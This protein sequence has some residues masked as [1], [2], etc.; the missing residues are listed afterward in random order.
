[1][2]PRPS[3]TLLSQVLSALQT[4]AQASA[5]SKGRVVVS[6]GAAAA[7]VSRRPATP[8]GL[9][10]LRD[11][12]PAPEDE[13]L[14]GH[15]RDG[16]GRGAR[17]RRGGA[18]H[19]RPARAHQL[20]R[21]RLLLVLVVVPVPGARRQAPPL[22]PRVRAGGAAA[23][24]ARARRQGGLLLRRLGGRRRAP[25]RGNDDARRQ[26]SRHALAVVVSDGVG[27]VGRR[28]VPRGAV[29]GPDD[30]GAARLQLL[31]GDLLL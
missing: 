24:T 26:C 11:P 7:T 29:R 17:L 20:P 8:L 6:N 25:A 21:R 28:G 9:L 27:G 1:R 23:A 3:T 15:L 16:G 2:P 13:D 5:S 12:P 4:A 22:Q 19:V 18:H 31:H 10:G 30:R 14:A